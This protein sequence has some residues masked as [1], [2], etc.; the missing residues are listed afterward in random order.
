MNTLTISDTQCLDA[1]LIMFRNTPET[2][3][4]SFLFV[5]GEDDEKFWNGYV[6]E[7][8][9]IVFITSFTKNNAKKTGKLQ[10][11]ENIGLLNKSRSKIKGYLGIV[12]ND[13]DSLSSISQEDNIC[14]T[15]THDLETLL[16]SST[17]VF[18]KVLAEFGDSQLIVD[19][20]KKINNSIQ[21]YLIELNLPFFQILWLRKNLN[22][23]LIL[24][25][26][27]KNN[28]ILIKDTWQVDKDKLFLLARNQGVDF[29]E[30]KSKIILQKIENANHWL[31]CHGHI[32]TYILANS[33]QNGVLANNKN[34]T[35]ER[36]SSYLRGAIDKIE[37][38]QT[39][40]CQAIF[41]WQNNNQPYVILS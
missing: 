24:D 36:I 40:L 41:N 19:F 17:S 15:E 31:L 12:D 8:C 25:D 14:V 37:L 2:K 18:K 21:N 5:E 13:F 20:E 1:A 32:M 30:N 6:A 38:Y 10:V 26:F 22:P 34:A 7:K 39:E 3:N 11:I 28:T 4:C 16:L 35:S 27:Y 9:C 33:F 23:S 29:Q